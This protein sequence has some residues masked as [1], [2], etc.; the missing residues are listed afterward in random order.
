M[1]TENV[2]NTTHE[3][4]LTNQMSIAVPHHETKNNSS[5]LTMTMVGKKA[6]ATVS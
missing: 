3:F 6:A 5:V 4:R 2:R 1:S